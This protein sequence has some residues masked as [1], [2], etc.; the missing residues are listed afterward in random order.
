LSCDA[1]GEITLREYWALRDIQQASVRRWAISQ[2]LA[3]NVHL[4]ADAE[5]F[6]ADDFLGT[7]DREKR[8]QIREESQLRVVLENK[9]LDKIKPVRSLDEDEPEGLPHWARMTPEEKAR[10]PKVAPPM[11]RGKLING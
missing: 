7:G 3:V 2:A 1:F 4:R 11:R 10:L 5:P 6:V 9:R 8:I